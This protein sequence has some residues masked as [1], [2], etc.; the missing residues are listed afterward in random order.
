MSQELP[1]I[2]PLV[3]ADCDLSGLTFMPLDVVRLLD[4]DMFNLSTPAEFKAALSLWC[5][6]WTQVPAASISSDPR[7][8]ARFASVSIDEWERLA[9]VA[10]RGWILCSDGR[11]YHTVVAE[12][13]LEAW[14][15][16]LGYQIRSGAANAKR[17]N[18]FFDE[19]SFR[20]K[21]TVAQGQLSRLIETT[22][23]NDQKASKLPQGEDNPPSR[24]EN[25]LPGG[26]KKPPKRREEKRREESKEEP[27]S[28]NVVLLSS[29]TKS[30][31]G[32]TAPIYDPNEFL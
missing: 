17:H 8:L 18:Y 9:P 1:V 26:A 28:E 22:R 21:I 24:S 2:D 32:P 23:P 20:D 5:K 31:G 29:R 11:Y 7:V 27:I 15:N 4:S 25:T 16:R 30:G 12:K 6:S 10:L 19:A 14:I 3:P 13:A